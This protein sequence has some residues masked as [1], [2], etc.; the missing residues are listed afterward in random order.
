MR[1]AFAR[2]VLIALGVKA[3]LLPSMKLLHAKTVM[4]DNKIAWAGSGN[5]TAAASNHNHEFYIR[6]TDPLA[7]SALAGFHLELDRL[8]NENFR[9]GHPA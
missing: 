1:N 7:V 5:W 2:D 6:T 8:A 9:P 4:I 3:F